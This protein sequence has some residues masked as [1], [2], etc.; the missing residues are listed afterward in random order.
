MCP[1]QRA[2]AQARHF[3]KFENALSAWSLDVDV[4]RLCSYISQER[5][6]I[7]PLVLRHDFTLVQGSVALNLFCP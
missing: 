4:P 2:T 1:R 7:P 5:E 3:A 6:L